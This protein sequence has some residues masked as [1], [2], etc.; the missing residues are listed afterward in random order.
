MRW[1]SCKLVPQVPEMKESFRRLKKPRIVK[2]MKDNFS[3]EEIL[4]T[5]E[6]IE[7]LIIMPRIINEKLGIFV[8]YFEKCYVNLASDGVVTSREVVFCYFF[9]TV[10]AR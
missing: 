7:S 8:L 5:E 1:I 2:R 10:K 9:V 6:V 3:R 4:V